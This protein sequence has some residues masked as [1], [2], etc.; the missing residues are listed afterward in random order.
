MKLIYCPHCHDI[1]KLSYMLTSCE[2]GHSFGQYNEDGLN[3]AYG[4]DAVPL[5]FANSSF[6]DALKNQPESG[7]GQCFEAF[8]IPKQCPTFVQVV[9]SKP[10]THLRHP[11][12]PYCDPHHPAPD[13]EVTYGGQVRKTRV[14]REDHIGG[15]NRRG[16]NEATDDQ[17]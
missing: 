10:P 12:E 6:V 16:S 4:G 17:R 13:E 14:K 1:R 9:A 15:F 7:L 3:A 5:G 11:D 8:V 2:C